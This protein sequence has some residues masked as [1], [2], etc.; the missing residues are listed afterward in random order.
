VIAKEGD[1]KKLWIGVCVIS[2]L[3]LL[4]NLCGVFCVCLYIGRDKGNISEELWQGRGVELC[5][6][7]SQFRLG[8]KDHK[9]RST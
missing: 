5:L 7:I 9:D 1:A 2:R 6:S 8:R 4:I 3:T